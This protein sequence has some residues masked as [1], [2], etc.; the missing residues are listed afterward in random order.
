MKRLLILLAVLCLAQ[1]AGAQACNATNTFVCDNFTV[2]ANTMVE[3]HA[4]NIGGA[5]T[6]QLGANGMIIN[7]A[8]DNVRNVNTGDWNEYSNATAPTGGATEVVV[9]IDVTFTA[10]P[11]N[12]N[13]FVDLFARGSVALIN[14]YIARLR[15]ANDGTGTNVQIITVT[16]GT[17]AIIASASV[18]IT[19]NAAHSF[20]FSV[21][22]AAKEIWIDGV[23][24]VTTANNAVATTGIVGFGQQS[25]GA[26]QTITDNY[27]ASVFAVTAVDRLDAVATRDA[28][29]TLHDAN[30]TLI[31]WST[32]REVRSLGFRVYGLA[33]TKRVPL[34]KGIVAG[35]AFMVSNASL[36]GGN[37]YRFV[38][39][40]GT[41]RAYWIEEIALDGK[42][43]W[44]GP[45]APRAGTLDSRIAISPT[46]IDLGQRNGV[47]P[48]TH[49]APAATSDA[50]GTRQRVT[51]PYGPATRKQWELAAQNTTK[52]AVRQTGLQRVTLDPSIDTA[53]LHL[54]ADGVEVPI[55]IQNNTILFYG[56]ALD[57]ASTDTHVYWLSSGN[58]AGLRMSTNP[59][60]SDAQA[61]GSGFR[62]TAERR[63]KTLYIAAI[64]NGE[65]DNFF[66]PVVSGDPAKP[67]T[68]V[69]R[70]QHIDRSATDAQL[71]VSLQGAS[72][73][74]EQSHRVTVA[75]NGHDA[76]ELSFT[77]MDVGTGSF[78]VPV[79]QL[80]EGDN[81][82]S[83]VARNGEADISTVISAAVTYQHTFD[84]DEGQLL[85]TVAANRQ[86][87][88]RGFAS[89]DL[90]L[91][92]VTNPATPQ[93]ITPLSVTGGVATFT[94]SGF[95][96]RTILAL[97][98]SRAFA[99]TTSINEPSML[100]AA[101]GDVVMITP[102]AFAPALTPLIQLR[103]QLGM[104][105]L[106]ANIDDVYDEFAYGA[107]DPQAI[108][109]F[110]MY[111]SGHW[112]TKPR[113]VLLLGDASLDPR[114]YL[115][116][117]D[118]DFVPTKMI[119]SALLETSS[120]TWFTDFDDDGA[121]DIPIGRL[122]VR[123]RADADIEVG[124]IVRY[125]TN[126]AQPSRNV[127]FV[128]DSD[129]DVNFHA[130]E[131]Q[132]AQSLPAGTPVIDVDVSA[133]GAAAARLQILG[134]FGDA[135][136]INYLGHGSVESWGNGNLLGRSDALALNN[137]PS[138]PI[139]L[140]ITCL[141][142]YFQD[143]YTESL[144]E[145]LLRA[146]N[147][148]AV[149][150]WASSALTSPESQIPVEAVLLRTLYTTPR[151]GDAVV[152]A[153]K[154]AFTPDM[155]RTFLLF[156]DPAMRVRAE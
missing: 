86:V 105:V 29:R 127:V 6:R 26:N 145:A 132:L 128:S 103:Q 82:I 68:Q 76:G 69:L 15:Q 19:T 137:S 77:G 111:A 13:N 66:G 117:G 12:T 146:P 39:P 27:F 154:S 99:P 126:P 108:R 44:H 1:R 123:T 149:A 35:A 60:T 10:A 23:L 112:Q 52:I 36:S 65:G 102:R 92:D 48:Q 138:L 95:G 49:I 97:D 61:A 88:I 104:K 147:G 118:Y 91:L 101:D 107:K 53:S 63:D 142:G 28:N 124:K 96:T 144:A 156:G 120:D 37:T 129:S 143:V 42:T 40:R 31:E 59:S 41:S 116:L 153:Q 139:V 90:L 30:R 57:T 134:R 100:H 38:D 94:T 81:T 140:A 131:Q 78:T 93:R 43:R 22:N 11:A 150:V 125:E 7:A 21:K 148:G 34:T 114:N 51:D 17:L 4:P 109:N 5:W 141:N 74:L 71:T 8:A 33:G 130:A 84:A 14:G 136:L 135:F 2:G 20:I 45:I 85:A 24:A 9:G 83:L 50:I 73:L 46:L 75:V 106:V 70:L 58:G 25:N 16:G 133:A 122:P 155:R 152:A 151:L 98:S 64:L 32:S 54:Y 110:L 47:A 72:D 3:A 87:A 113:Y 67:T 79:S 119:A 55:L 80:A 18:A 115:G 89:S 121:A 56:T 62:A